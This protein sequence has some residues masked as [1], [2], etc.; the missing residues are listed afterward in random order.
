[1]RIALLLSRVPRCCWVCPVCVKGAL[2]LAMVPCL[3]QGCLGIAY[4]A[5]SL[6]RVPRLCK[7]CSVC[8]KG[9][10]ALHTVPCLSQG[11]AP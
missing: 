9:A 8:V 6:S 3:C 11:C 4:S 1:M 7:Q 5:L 10:S 2:S